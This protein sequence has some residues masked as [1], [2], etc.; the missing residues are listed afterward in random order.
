[1]KQFL[2]HSVHFFSFK[3]RTESIEKYSFIMCLNLSSFKKILPCYTV[4]QEPEPPELHRNFFPEPEPQKNEAAPQHYSQV[5][6]T[7]LA[8]SFSLLVPGPEPHHFSY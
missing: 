2:I 5:S 8:S 4:G 3:N 1:M 7:G 6:Q